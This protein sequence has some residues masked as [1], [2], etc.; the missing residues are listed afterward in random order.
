MC[1][2]TMSSWRTKAKEKAIQ[3]LMKSNFIF[4]TLLHESSDQDLDYGM[5]CYHLLL[6]LFSL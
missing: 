3:L 1:L 5:Y 6:F 2:V 4:I